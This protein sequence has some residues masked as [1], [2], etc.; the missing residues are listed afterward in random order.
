MNINEIRT[1]QYVAFESVV[2]ITPLP[3]LLNN[4]PHPSEP[5][6]QE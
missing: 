4:G 1:E 6:V 2:G 3:V 5:G